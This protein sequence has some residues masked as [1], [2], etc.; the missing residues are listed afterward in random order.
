MFYDLSEFPF[1]KK[2]LENRDIIQKEFELNYAHPILMKHFANAPKEYPFYEEAEAI[3]KW[4]TENN[5]H[6]AQK[7]YDSRIGEW[8]AFPLYKRNYEIK[9]YNPKKEFPNTL[10]LLQD[11]PKINLAGFFRIKP[12]SG[13]KEHAHSQ[14]H[15]IFHLCLTDLIGESEIICEGERK[16]LC[17]KG[18][19]CLFDYSKL[20]SSFNF[21]SNDRINFIIDF[22]I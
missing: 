5:I 21:S 2:I 3:N 17:K 4:V 10:K 8:T 20:H 12:N 22:E 1:L 7:G 18:D 11:I 9:W 16:V 6:P 15:F 14:K 13:T 19:W